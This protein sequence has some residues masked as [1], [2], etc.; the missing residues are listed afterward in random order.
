MKTIASKVVVQSLMLTAIAAFSSSAMS[1]ST[2]L[3]GDNAPVNE[4]NAAEVSA[5]TCAPQAGGDA[6]APN[7]KGYAYSSTATSGT[8]FAVATLTSYAGGLGVNASGEATKSPQHAI[9]NSGS[10]DL[11]LLDFG[12]KKVDLD[13]VTIGWKGN[14]TGG[15]TSSNP[16]DADISVFRYTGS[17]LTLPAVSGLLATGA[18]LLDGGW[19][20]VGNYADLVT[21]T[22]KNVNTSNATSSWWLVSAYNS[23]FGTT[24]ESSTSGLTGG[25]DYF[26]VLSV[27]GAYSST[28]KVPEPGSLALFGLGLVGLVAS[29]RR[30]QKVV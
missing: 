29:R 19:T 16:A 18:G 15:N 26:K 9:D 2:W 13:S 4:C 17:S 8:K 14:S 7:V 6:G 23:N 5:G 24:G 12:S 27:A 20:L 22:A 11:V 21:G 10:T 28:S 30:S 25:N 1:A 3:F